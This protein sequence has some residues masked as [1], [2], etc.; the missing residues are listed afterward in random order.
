MYITSC[1]TRGWKVS[2]KGVYPN[3][4]RLIFLVSKTPG[5]SS[6]LGPK[7]WVVQRMER[8]GV[9]GYKGDLSKQ[10]LPQS[11]I[12]IAGVL[13]HTWTLYYREGSR[14]RVVCVFSNRSTNNFL[15]EVKRLLL[16]LWDSPVDWTGSSVDRSPIKRV[17]F[18]HGVR[19]KKIRWKP[20]PQHEDPSSLWSYFFL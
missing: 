11:I 12:S 18:R 17:M 7:R 4:L 6:S 13:Y 20:K 10:H 8:F 14:C 5:L 9:K 19:Y 2:G 3:T 1:R 16:W 15:I